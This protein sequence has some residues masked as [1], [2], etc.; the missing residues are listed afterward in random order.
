MPIRIGSSVSSPKGKGKVTDGDTPMTD[1]AVIP[2]VDK[3][4]KWSKVE[5]PIQV[6]KNFHTDNPIRLL[7][8]GHNDNIQAQVANM[9]R[10]VIYIF[11]RRFNNLIREMDQAYTVIQ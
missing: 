6:P 8:A 2:Y 1:M 7:E 5:P 11:E 4:G 10:R 9:E 3:D